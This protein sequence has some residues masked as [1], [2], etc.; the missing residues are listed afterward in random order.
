MRL[1]LGIALTVFGILLQAEN[2]PQWRGPSLNGVSAETNLPVK[3]TAD[4]G[5]AWKI[6]LAERSGATPIVWGDHIFLSVAEKGSLY[7]WAVSARDGAVQWK[8]H[9][10]DGDVIMRKQNMSSPSPV[11][12]GEWVW[13]LTGTGILK[14]FDFAG[15]EKW[16]RDIQQDYGRFGVNWGYASSPLLYG[17]AIYVQVIHGMRTKDPS[18]ILKFDAA[19]N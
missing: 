1:R 8:K 10:G 6:P 2:W 7:L 3:W 11:T 4:E 9:L 15:V 19:R 14:A 5:I 13:A 18:Y 12:D 17:D 16:T